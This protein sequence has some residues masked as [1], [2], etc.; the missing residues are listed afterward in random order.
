MGSSSPDQL[1][2][3]GGAPMDVLDIG[4]TL[5]G[6]YVAGFDGLSTHAGHEPAERLAAQWVPF[7]Q[8]L[9]MKLVRIEQQFGRHLFVPSAEVVLKAVTRLEYVAA[10]QNLG[11]PVFRS[12]QR[13]FLL[14][15][16]PS[17]IWRGSVVKGSEVVQTKSCSIA[18]Y[19]PF[20]ISLQS[21]AK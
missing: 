12:W 20:A 16:Q 8:R 19:P 1:R 18:S 6:H 11:P 13:E 15:L 21:A 7:A 5:T 3:A 9:R 4:D 14:G 17:G 2:P 10:I